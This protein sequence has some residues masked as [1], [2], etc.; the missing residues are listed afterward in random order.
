[1]SIP[2]RKTQEQSDKVAFLELIRMSEKGPF[3][4]TI[5]WLFIKCMDIVPYSIF[6]NSTA[7]H[8]PKIT[9]S[10]AVLKDKFGEVIQLKESLLKKVNV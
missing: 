4:I 10:K 7:C 3:S 9:A 5:W 8:E 6:T 2:G 1:M